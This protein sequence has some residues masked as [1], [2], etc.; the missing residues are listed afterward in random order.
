MSRPIESYLVRGPRLTHPVGA[1][2]GSADPSASNLGGSS[3]A[4]LPT[5]TD[6]SGTR[7]GCSSCTA[8]TTIATIDATALSSRPFTGSTVGP[9]PSTYGSAFPFATSAAAASTVTSNVVDEEEAADD[10]RRR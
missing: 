6:I 9:V 8:P 5:S 7:S 4:A 1:S 10:E 2:S 3:V